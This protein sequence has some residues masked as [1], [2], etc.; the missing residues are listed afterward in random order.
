M[1]GRDEIKW[2]V[3]ECFFM[4]FSQASLATQGNGH[5]ETGKR[6][7]KENL[8]TVEISNRF[9]ILY[10]SAVDFIYIFLSVYIYT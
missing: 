10:V 8:E 2:G 6:P 3:M 5:L 1:A 9:L 7:W 4:D